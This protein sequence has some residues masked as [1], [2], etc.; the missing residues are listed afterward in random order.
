MKRFKIFFICLFLFQTI[1]V[2]A[3]VPVRINVTAPEVINAGK[4]FVLNFE[5]NNEGISGFAKLE[6]FLPVGF[7]PVLIEASGATHIIQNDMIKIIWIELPDKPKF[8]LSINIT[9]DKRI[10][11]YKELFGNFHYITNKE[12]VKMSFGIVPF[13]VKN[14][15]IARNEGSQIVE[16]T[17][18][19]IK[20]VSPERNLNLKTVYRI[21]IAA[22][23]RKL[24][25]E[26]LSEL[27]MS[28]SF[29]KEEI[30]DGLYKYS[31]GDFVSKDDADSFRQ[32]CGI[33]GAFIV[34]YEDGKRIINK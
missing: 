27:F 14:D 26:I 22:F 32:K 30:I 31:I 4:E 12:R 6:I 9:V 7:K 21:Q 19:N 17:N 11:G 1:H 8:S 15:N 28:P 24:S 33:S 34:K 13:Q 25:K 2:L 20:S 5:F 18:A 10:S 29:I 3:A 23:K 16:N